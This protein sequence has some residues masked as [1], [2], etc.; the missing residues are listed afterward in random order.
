LVNNEVRRVTLCFAA[1]A[2]FC[3]ALF[4][5]SASPA[6]QPIDVSQWKTFANRAGWSIKHPGS[7]EIGGCR[8][9]SDPAAPNV[10]V[11]LYNPLT[12]ELIMT[13]PLADKPAGQT[14]E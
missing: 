3:T 13:E 8:S 12:K 1:Y 11:S 10:F 9:C 6:D 2:V 7:W 4:A 5:Q 14:V